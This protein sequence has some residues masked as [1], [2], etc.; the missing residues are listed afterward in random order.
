MKDLNKSSEYT[1]GKKRNAQFKK[2]KFYYDHTNSTST[3]RVTAML[4]SKS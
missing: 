1:N 2:P 4:A 3:L